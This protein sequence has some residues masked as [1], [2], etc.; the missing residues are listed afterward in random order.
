MLCFIAFLYLNSVKK[1]YTGIKLDTFHPL[2]QSP[3]LT[4]NIRIHMQGAY[5]LSC[6]LILFVV[7]KLHIDGSS[8]DVGDIKH[9]ELLMLK[10]LILLQP[11]TLSLTRRHRLFQLTLLFCLTLIF[12]CPILLES[13]YNG[14]FNI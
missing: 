12:F 7:T 2:S 3:L 1:K 13:P 5:F 14:N 6:C 11:S 8:K 4:S 9:N 10:H